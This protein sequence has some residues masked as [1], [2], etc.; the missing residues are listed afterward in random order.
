MSGRVLGGV[1]IGVAE[2]LGLPVWLVRTGFVVTAFFGGLGVV[3]YAAG[4]LLLRDETESESVATRIAR[5]IRSGPAWVGIL[6]VGLGA[7]LM[8][9]WL[10]YMPGG[11]FA[12]SRS[13]L[14]ALLFVVVGVL[15]YRGD[16]GG[17]R[18]GP[19]SP[20]GEAPLAPPAPPTHDESAPEGF[21]TPPPPPPPPPALYIPPAPAVPPPPPPPPS[22]LGRLTI[23][24]GML[25]LGVLAVLDNVTNLVSPQPRHY[26]ALATLVLGLGLLVGAV[27]G[28]ARWLILVG[29]FVIPPLLVSPATE[30]SWENGFDQFVVPTQVGELSR[31]YTSTVGSLTLDLTGIEWNGETVELDARMAAGEIFVVVPDNVAITGAARVN[32]GEVR[33]PSGSQAGVGDITRSISE[34]GEAGTV[35]LDLEMGVG[36]IAVEHVPAPVRELVPL[37]ASDLVDIGRRAGDLS[38]DLTRLDLYQDAELNV[39]IEQGD[40][41]VL[42]PSDLNVRIAAYSNNGD[43]VV[44]GQYTYG[45]GYVDSD[46]TGPILTIYLDTITGNINVERQS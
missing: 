21:S 2:S 22:I 13:F 20:T 8:I 39:F 27:Y 19:P 45:D 1:A 7:M 36:S 31:S 4:W 33:V 37:D 10:P 6:L 17:P 16:I 34:S 5:N 35:V 42:V 41:D 32:I 44:F 30:M 43:A 23:G 46:G 26:L 38:V 9:G 28:R 15:L 14:W 24:V 18:S 29:F 3:L 40:I 11:T 25:A 12:P